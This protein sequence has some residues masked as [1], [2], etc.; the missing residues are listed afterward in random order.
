[1]LML[2][3]HPANYRQLALAIIILSAFLLLIQTVDYVNFTVDDVFIPLRIGQNVSEGFGFVYNKGDFVEGH[4]DPLWVAVMASFSTL[5]V[6]GQE[7]PYILLWIAKGLSYLFG[8][9]CLILTYRFLQ[10]M[11]YLSPAKNF[12]AALGVL[13]LTICSPFILWSCSG[14]E[15]TF[16]AF[17]YLVTAYT[18]Y[19][20]VS[21]KN[22]AKA[23]PFII[24]GITFILASLTR[25]EAPLFAATGFTFLLFASKQRK[26]L[27][28]FSVVPYI[29]TCGAF[30]AWRYS[31]YGDLLPSAFYAKT[32]NGLRAFILGVKY[33]IGSFGGVSGPLI[34]ALPFVLSRRESLGKIRAFMLVFVGTTMIFTIYSSGDWMPAFRFLVLIAPLIAIL[35]ILSIRIIVLK[36]VSERSFSCRSVSL[37]ASIALIASTNVFVMRELIRASNN[38]LATGFSVIKGFGGGEHEQV[39]LWLRDH[40]KE[41]ETVAT[42]EAGLIG[43]LNPS[44]RLLDLNGLMDRKI[45]RDR[46]AGLAFDA[47]YI[48]KSAPEYILLYGLNLFDQQARFIPAWGDYS[49][50]LFKHP[51]FTTDYEHKAQFLAFDIYK[52]K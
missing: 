36:V 41:N 4:S 17:L 30:L 43:Y 50:Y 47:E 31:T 28:L 42:G 18:A 34:L 23:K 13:A 2:T 45:A 1:M 35:G 3:Q 19:D 27:I 48:L 7:S 24:I 16:V 29:L 44:M 25:P 9:L 52:R 38:T 12:Y 46:K 40:L 6:G 20:I 33:F 5:G 14:L 39:A 10:R 37:L 32:G 49:T 11:L 15:M 8:I 22:E 26:Q 21:S 51:R